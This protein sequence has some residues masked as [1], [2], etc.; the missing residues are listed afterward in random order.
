[1]YL[2]LDQLL[3]NDAA[4]MPLYYEEFTR[5]IPEYVKDFPQNGIEYRDFASVWIDSSRKQGSRS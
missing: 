4:V 3:M 5:L 1:M 2:Q